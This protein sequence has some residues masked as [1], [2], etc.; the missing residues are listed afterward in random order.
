MLLRDIPAGFSGAKAACM[1]VVDGDGFSKCRYYQA[2]GLLVLACS[3]SGQPRMPPLSMAGRH[4]NGNW[5]ALSADD[6]SGSLQQ[7]PFT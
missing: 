6:L 4:C 7:L 5:L 1:A 2:S 3:G